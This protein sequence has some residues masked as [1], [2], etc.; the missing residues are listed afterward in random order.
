MKLMIVS[1]S[2]WYMFNLH[3]LYMS[4][5]FYFFFIVSKNDIK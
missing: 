5:L 4:K 2:V 1:L 3:M